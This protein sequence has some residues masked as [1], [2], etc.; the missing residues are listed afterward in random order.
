MEQIELSSKEN[1]IVKVSVLSY[2]EWCTANPK[3]KKG[4]YAKKEEECD[5][6]DGSGE[7]ICS[8]GD[9]HDCTY[10]MGNGTITIS[11]RR[12]EDELKKLYE[13][14]KR[15]NIRAFRVYL[16]MPPEKAGE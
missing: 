14:E 3:I 8:C 5:I 9:E 11:K 1:G 15:D 12:M 6:C 16:G 4:V 13:Q 2:E 7:C 10:C